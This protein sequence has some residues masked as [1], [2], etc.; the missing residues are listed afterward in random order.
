[1]TILPYAAG[2]LTVILLGGFDIPATIAGMLIVNYG[3][4][5]PES[6]IFAS[7]VVLMSKVRILVYPPKQDEK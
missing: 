5:S 6:I 2:M 3:A 7:S 4:A 1:M